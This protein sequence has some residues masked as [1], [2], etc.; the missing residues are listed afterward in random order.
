MLTANGET[1]V[2]NV[3]DDYEEDFVKAMAGKAGKDT[4]GFDP[5]KY[6]AGNVDNKTI[7]DVARVSKDFGIFL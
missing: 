1:V 6:Y 7:N 3:D 5:N 4:E 2:A